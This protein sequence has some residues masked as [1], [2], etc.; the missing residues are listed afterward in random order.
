M[1][2]KN[3]KILFR[4]AGGKARKKEL[5]LGHIYRCINLASEFKK[6]RVFFLIEDYGG[7]KQ[8]IEKNGFKN[9]VIIKNGVSLNNDIKSTIKVIEENKIDI[10]IIDNFHL[11]KE[12]AKKLKKIVKVVVITDL[13][14]IEF[15]ADLL[16][17]GFVGFK[18]GII[19]NKYKTK[20]LLGP[21]YQILNKN[22]SKKI[23]SNKEK[24]KLLVTLGG[25]DEKKY[26]RSYSR[27][28]NKFKC[29]N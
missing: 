4:T 29:K 11:K 22:F 7:V 5:G 27:G 9:H 25:L 14:N 12:Y 13:E 6:N 8:I 23:I 17:N 26:F 1:V 24:Y 21:K 15:E 18:N 19:K 3:I 16:V 10:L 20:C 28:T 2:T